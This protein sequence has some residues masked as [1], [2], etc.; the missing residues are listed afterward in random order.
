M[1][2]ADTTP[3]IAAARIRYFIRFGDVPEGNKSRMWTAPNVFMHGRI[4]QILPGLSAYRAKRKGR[5]WALIT[6]DV[7]VDSGIASLFECFQGAVN[8]PD[9]NKIYLLKGV[10]T[11]WRNMTPQERKK[12][13]DWYPGE[14]REGSDIL[15]TDGE[16]LVRNFEIV[17]TVKVT[18]LI[19]KMIAFPEDWEDEPDQREEPGSSDSCDCE[20]DPAHRF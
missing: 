14:G 3:G 1:S 7:N 11:T 12:F 9:T 18:D 2:I 13:A 4:G 10:A 16:P 19:C 8:T 5:K 6:D 20:M 17:S 15:G